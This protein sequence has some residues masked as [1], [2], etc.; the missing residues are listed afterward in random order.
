MMKKW[1]LIC[2]YALIFIAGLWKSNQII[3][4]ITNENAFLLPYMFPLAVF[5]GIFPVIPYGLFGGI[6]GAKFGPLWGALINWTGSFGSAFLI[7]L[8]VRYGYQKAG[9][10]FLARYHQLDRFTTVFERNA[11]IAVL[12]ARLIPIVPSPVI[13]IYSAISS[14]PVLSFALATAIG[15]VPTMIMFSILGDQ[16]FHDL[17]RTLVTLLIYAM[18][19]GLAYLLYRMWQSHHRKKSTS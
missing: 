2:I 10:N 17:R 19:V 11:F 6:M 16:V 13:N 15:K 4:W 1:I 18:F 3:A 14:I 8:F 9:R 5:I 7:F 12:F